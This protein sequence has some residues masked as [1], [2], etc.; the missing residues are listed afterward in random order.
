MSYCW[1]AVMRWLRGAVL[2]M[3]VPVSDASWNELDSLKGLT[4]VPVDEVLD[5]KMDAPRV[6]VLLE[7]VE[8][9]KRL[10]QEVLRVAQ[11]AQAEEY[12][13]AVLSGENRPRKIAAQRA[14][15]TQRVNL[16]Q[17]RFMYHARRN[18]AL[19]ELWE[20]S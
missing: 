18:E 10:V 7:E 1:I 15:D 8:R 12:V 9:Q 4:S 13:M 3:G 5:T 2:R 16:E 19:R 14:V 17:M 11:V 6:D 20:E